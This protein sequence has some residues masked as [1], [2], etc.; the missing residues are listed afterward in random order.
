MPPWRGSFLVSK[1]AIPVHHLGLTRAAGA[2]NVDLNAESVY[3]AAR[4][5]VFGLILLARS[6][7]WAALQVTSQNSDGRLRDE[8]AGVK[9][10]R[11]EL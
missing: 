4:N 2:T 6:R 7:L 8:R 11:K 10:Q 1:A 9:Q 3:V 5:L